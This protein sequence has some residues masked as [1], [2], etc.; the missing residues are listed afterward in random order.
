MLFH[1]ETQRRFGGSHKDMD[2]L[3]ELCCDG[4][5]QLIDNLA[6]LPSRST[7]LVI[8][9]ETAIYLPQTWLGVAA[10][11]CATVIYNSL[12]PDVHAEMDTLEAILLPMLDAPVA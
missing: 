4:M 9:S 11:H 8:H 2:A 10:A 6:V 12:G 7:I 1:G 5:P 3:D